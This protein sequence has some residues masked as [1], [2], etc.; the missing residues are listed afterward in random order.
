METETTT[1]GAVDITNN[2]A[3]E[4][5]VDTIS[6]PKADYETLNQTLGSLKRE[7]KDLK[8]SKEEVKVEIKPQE[9]V[10]NDLGEKAYLAVNGIKTP[11]E[12][13]FVQKL[14][15]ETGKDV[16]SLLGSTYFQSELREFK[17]K[18]ASDKA[19]PTGS[20]RSSNSSIDSVEYWIAKDELPPASEVELR[21]KVVNAKMGKEKPT[22]VF[23]NS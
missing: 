10:T 20:K 21:R 23:Y 16:E 3:G 19:T 22:G 14:K 15:K 5:K 11:D 18:A 12:I 8:K 9:T 13:A 4:A 1:E 7:L 6:I 2:E 17:E